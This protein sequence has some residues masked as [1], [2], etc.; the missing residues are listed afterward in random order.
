MNDVF[1]IT[2]ALYT[3]YG[4]FSFEERLEQTI[5]TALSI[6]QRVPNALIYLLEGGTTE[7]KIKLREKLLEHYNDVIDFSNH[8][9]I[10][11]AHQFSTDSVGH[12]IKG[13]IESLMLAE[14]CKMLLFTGKP[15]ID[16]Q[17]VF[18]VSG[19]YELT[20][21]FNLLDHHNAKGKYLFLNKAKAGQLATVGK[22]L[23]IF[24]EFCY[25]T[26]MYSFCG[27]LLEKAYYN[28]SNIFN[29]IL[30]V[31]STQNYIDVETMTYITVSTHDVFEI[32][33]IGLTGKLAHDGSEVKR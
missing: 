16:V 13:P 15:N 24:S 23:M 20:D 33:T 19:R 3:P 1:L 12:T 22:P 32:S 25:E 28:Y 17:R 10:V 29:N 8:D 18:K 14:A 31:Y 26:V 4:C 30:D 27:S 5:N 7:L 11:K 2:S 21:D 9:S 6:R